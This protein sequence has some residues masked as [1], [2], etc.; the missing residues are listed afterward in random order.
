MEHQGQRQFPCIPVR[1]DV[2]DQITLVEPGPFQTK[3]I[4]ENAIVLPP[5]PAYTNEAL[6]TN[7][8]RKWMDKG[9]ASGDPEKAAL[10]FLK[11]AAL[12]DPPFRFPIHKNAIAD[13]RAKA[14]S[15]NEAADKWESWSENVYH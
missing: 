4:K 6:P 5:H 13:A 3:A 8:A 10:A 12:E 11:I 2:N 14:E 15:L 9:E 7:L 1:S